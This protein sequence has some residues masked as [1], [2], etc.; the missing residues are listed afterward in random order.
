MRLDKFIADMTPY[1]RNDIKKLI[2]RG[3]VSVD[4]KKA[5]S[6]SQQVQE[7]SEVYLD[8][9]LITYQRYEY[10]LLNKPAGYICANS[11][12]SAPVALELID[13][14]RR[15]LSCVGRLDKDTEGAL[16]I[17]NDGQLNHAL[18]SANNHVEKT[19]YARFSGTLP[20]NAAE[21]MARGISFKEFT[22]RPARL[23]VIDRQSARLTIC[24]GKFHQVKRMFAH[25]G[26]DVTY[27]RRDVFAGLTLQG[28][29][30]GEYRPLDSQE[31]GQLWQLADPQ[32]VKTDQLT[33]EEDS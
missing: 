28:L 5:V 26:C 13:S 18:L 27:L 23:E 24:E 12:V 4:G 11:D 20:D 9:Q 29:E 33:A 10:Y 30:V 16:L 3:A 19:Y 1:S 31:V 17:T 32:K 22:S 2:R 6:G 25:F 15:D 14:P 8:D 7:D 21:V